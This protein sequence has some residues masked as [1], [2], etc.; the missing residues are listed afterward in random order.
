MGRKGDKRGQHSGKKPALTI[1]F[2]APV[3]FFLD[4]LAR[5]VDRLGWP[6]VVCGLGFYYLEKHASEE[7]ARALIDMYLLGK[8][9]QAIW[10]IAAVS[11]VWIGVGSACRWY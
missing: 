9:T 8:N 3:A 1:Y 7:Q 4:V 10:P 6:A 2:G 11:G 5:L